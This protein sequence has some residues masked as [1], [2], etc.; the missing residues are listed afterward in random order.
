MKIKE[1]KIC[2]E[3]PWVTL[4]AYLPFTRDKKADALLIIPGGG[5]ENVCDGHEGD[6][7][8]VDFAARG[9]RCFVLRYSVKKD[10]RFPTPLIDASLAVSHI[11]RNA[12]EYGI[13][14]ERVFVLGFSAG[15]H[16]AAALG[17]LWHKDW[18]CRHLGMPFGENRPAG[19]ILCYPVLAYFPGTNLGTFY[20]AFG[21][22]TPT[23]EMINELSLERQ[24]DARTV[25]AF[26]WHTADDEGVSVENTLRMLRALCEAKIYT[27]AHIYPHG[28]HGM[29]LA[30]DICCAAPW[31]D[32]RVAHWPRLAAEWIKTVK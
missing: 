30:T 2:E 26:L 10:A 28:P 13:D 25:P 1:V 19:M 21:T 6:A 15:G 17:T 3:R 27:E 20:H 9:L 31:T 12:E 5:Y 4:S 32:P 16:L 11:K 29:S 7:V 23:E 24:V 14:P 8:A 22:D 18:L